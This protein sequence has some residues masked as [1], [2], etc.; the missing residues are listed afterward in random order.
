ML[1]HS[2]TNYVDGYHAGYA[3]GWWDGVRV[4]ITCTLLVLGVAAVGAACF[5]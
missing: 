2:P 5:L 1:H 3:T 4:V